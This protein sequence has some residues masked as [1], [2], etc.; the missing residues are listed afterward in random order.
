MCYQYQ[1]KYG[2]IITSLTTWIFFLIFYS[3]IM[4]LKTFSTLLYHPPHLD[5]THNNIETII[6]III[7][8]EREWEREIIC[9][10]ITTV[11]KMI[12]QNLTHFENHYERIFLFITQLGL[13]LCVLIIFLLP[14]SLLLKLIMLREGFITKPW[15]FFSCCL[16]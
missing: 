1:Q 13:F 11:L 3:L 10:E 15:P 5:T 7:R 2:K 14:L 12:I 8:R 4:T 6:I 16:L 9:E